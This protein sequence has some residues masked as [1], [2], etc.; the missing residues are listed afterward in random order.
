MITRNGVKM[1]MCTNLRNS[2]IEY[3]KFI[4]FRDRT[5]KAEVMTETTKVFS[6]QGI[7]V[8]STRE[9]EKFHSNKV[10]EEKNRIIGTRYRFA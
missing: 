5:S 1:K 4:S 6:A 7:K 8:L 10:K 3:F 9:L 2:L